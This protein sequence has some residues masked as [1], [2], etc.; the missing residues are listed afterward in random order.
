M[1]EIQHKDFIDLVPIIPCQ[2]LSWIMDSR[3]YRERRTNISLG[4]PTTIELL[5]GT[6]SRIERVYTDIKIASDTK[7]N[8]IIVSFTDQIMLFLVT[9]CL[10]KLNLEKVK[11]TLIILFPC[12]PEFS[13]TTKWLVGI[14]QFLF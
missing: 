5:F 14:H 11:C 7:I 1:V 9:D 13:S 4:S 8:H 10:Q 2:K 6:R 12:K 3:I